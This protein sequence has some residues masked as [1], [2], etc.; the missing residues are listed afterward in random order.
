MADY[1]VLTP[2]GKGKLK[3]ELAFLKGE[4][5]LEI[6]KRI[7]LAKE[8]GDLSENA[9]YHDAREEQS[10]S[11]GRILEIEN[12][13]KTAVTPDTTSTSGIKVSD[14]VTLEIDGTEI[15]YTIVG[16]HESKPEENLISCDSPMGE[17][18]L[19][20]NEGEEVEIELPK[21]IVKYLIKKVN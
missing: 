3:K 4:K 21:G 10:F 9:E 20:H 7:E 13:L 14:K 2:E 15:I 8:H 19:G 17:A 18:L 1:P 16:S 6:K 5:R 12:I 11:E